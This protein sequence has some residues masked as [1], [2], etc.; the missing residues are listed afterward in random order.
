[1]HSSIGGGQTIGK[2]LLRIAV[3]GRNNRPIRT[4]RSFLRISILAV[5]AIFNG[6]QLPMF[7]TPLA[8]LLLT[9]IVFG[10]GAAI[11]YTMVFNRARQGL[12]D[13]ICGTYVVHLPGKPIE[14]FPQTAR[15][16]WAIS[17]VLVG[18]AVV[19]GAAARPLSSALVPRAALG[20]LQELYQ[21]LNTD[22][23]FFTVGVNDNTLYS[24]QGMTV[25]SL[26]VEVWYRGV[27]S[28]D[29][30]RSIIND[31]ATVVLQNAGNI[32]QYDLMR[33]SVTSA[34]DLGIAAGH[35]TFSDSQP[36]EVW[37]E[38]VGPAGSP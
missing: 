13:L 25:H 33:I 15:V 20:P 11:L 9:V 27:P 2:R 8:L 22:G 34:Y 1:M 26:Q 36:I 19:L 24:T 32:G 10:F 29:E 12:H 5:P 4:G 3:R 21:T 35:L 7:Q 14:T 38:R 6:W 31:V 17:A 37:R 28:N 16:H 18:L 30:R 23:R